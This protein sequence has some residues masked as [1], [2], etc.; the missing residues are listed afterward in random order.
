[1]AA[2]SGGMGGFGGGF[3]GSFGGQ[4]GE[5][6]RTNAT[7]V[8][9]QG[10]TN[11]RSLNSAP[12]GQTLT[13]AA[14]NE[15]P[16]AEVPADPGQGLQPPDN[17]MPNGQTPNG[18]TP[19]NQDGQ[20]P[21]GMGGQAPGGQFGQ[22]PGGFDDDFGG[23]FGAGGI[24]GI[25]SAS[26]AQSQKNFDEAITTAIALGVLGLAGVFVTMYKRRRL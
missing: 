19:M 11:R 3:G 12:S 1:V 26:T 7:G 8:Q 14:A 2:A 20:M 10:D 5:R 21:G 13:L 23:G 25:G 6:T 15:A 4:R 22:M 18:Q 17:Q 24:P 9:T 16:T